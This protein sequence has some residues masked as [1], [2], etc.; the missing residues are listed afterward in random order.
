MTTDYEIAAIKAAETLIKYDITTAPIDPLKILKSMPDVLILSFTEM[1]NLINVD[2]HTAVTMF[3]D[4]NQDAVTTCFKIDGKL[5]YVIAFN[6]RLPFY[7]LQRAFARELGHI[8]LGHDGTRPEDVRTEEAITFAR[9]FLCPRALIKTVQ[10]SGVPFTIELLGA[11][12]GCYERCL[13]GM[14]KTPGTHVPAELNRQIKA[15]FADYISNLLDFHAVLS[16]GD[17]NTP[18]AFGTYMDFYE[19]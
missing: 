19:E 16:S 3:G 5:K 8:V 13:I 11:M 18:V 6:Q 14:K 17:D 9:H 4:T 12:T 15:N 2:R 1:A 10:E 7:L